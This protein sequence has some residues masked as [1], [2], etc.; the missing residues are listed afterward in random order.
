MRFRA[1]LI[2]ATLVLAACSSAEGAALLDAF[3]DAVLDEAPLT[4][5]D[6]PGVRA[7][8]STVE[9]EDNKQRAERQINRALKPDKSPDDKIRHAENA[10]IARPGDPTYYVY[11]A[12]FLSL[13][14][15]P[16]VV[17]AL[18]QAKGLLYL[19]FAHISDPERRQRETDRR[20]LELNLEATLAQYHAAPENSSDREGFKRIYC[21]YRT[22]YQEADYK[23]DSLAGQAQWDFVIDHDL[24]RSS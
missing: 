5:S 22:Q 19:Q 23:A 6:D 3:I 8:G 2:A 11:L 16:G 1:L 13:E 9:D 7:A 10:I 18:G 12:W 14:G 21:N 17:D 24:C 15:K 20:L 4:E